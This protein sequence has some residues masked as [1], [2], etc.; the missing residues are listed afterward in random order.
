MRPGGLRSILR[1]VEAAPD[2]KTRPTAVEVEAFLGSVPDS[3]RREEGRQVLAL[4][5]EV[6]GVD[7]VMWGPSMVGFG[8]QPYTT[9]DGRQRSWFAV[10]FSPRKAALT[11][12]GLTY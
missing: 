4:M 8:H 6:T 11:L 1:R 9:A 5:R 7:P 10:G 2:R 12:Y 3:R